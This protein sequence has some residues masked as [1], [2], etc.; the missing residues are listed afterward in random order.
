MSNIID[1]VQR[2]LRRMP[3]KPFCVV[4]SLVLTELA[5]VNFIGA[6]PEPRLF[7][8]PVRIG[9]LY[10]AE[11]FDS[12]FPLLQH[13]NNESAKGLW[14]V[15]INHRSLLFAMAASPR[16]RDI[17]MAFRVERFNAER[18]QQFAAVTFLL[19]DDTAFVSFRGTDSTIVGWKEDFNM[20]FISPVPSQEEAAAYL[21]I[22]GKRLPRTKLRAGGH[23][24]GGNLAV[25]AAMKCQPTVQSRILQAYN[26]DGPGFKDS[27]LGTPEYQAIEKRI[28]KIL[29]QSS[30]VGM[31][32]S[33]RE[34]FSVVESTRSGLMQHDGYSWE[35]KDD[36]FVYAEKLT[37]G[38]I[39]M[40][41]T[42]NQWLET[43]PDDKRQLLV[44][45]LFQVIETT[46]AD[47]L[48][49][50]SEAWGKSALTMLGTYRNLDVE[51]KRLLS[52]IIRA[53]LKLSVTNL[54]KDKPPKDT[55]P[56]AD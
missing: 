5:Y 12:M 18:A 7:A 22:V 13:Y 35:V 19:E 11:L 21:N 53:L 51:T 37:G 26:H 47:T 49:D 2:E 34:D 55:L 8:K 17:R 9:D 40:H 29:P 36:D 6:V 44:D 30:V 33:D 16:F 25:Y 45:A 46:Q 54:R 4:D 14:S 24:K 56:S 20:A 31:L 10:K 1:Y 32:L 52:Q 42:L 38:A 48:F 28:I 3:E 39:Y 43:L 27:V 23:S 15:Q 50:I 41:K